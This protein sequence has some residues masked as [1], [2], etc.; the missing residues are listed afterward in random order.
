MAS[1]TFHEADTILDVQCWD[2]SAHEESAVDPMETDLPL[3]TAS[4]V[5]AA[6]ANTTTAPDAAAAVAIF[7]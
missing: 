2:S 6:S 3:T 7:H 5:A 4:A 1:P